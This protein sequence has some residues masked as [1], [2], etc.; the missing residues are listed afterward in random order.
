VDLSSLNGF[1]LAAFAIL[2]II[3]LVSCGQEPT[4]SQSLQNQTSTRAQPADPPKGEYLL[5]QPPQGWVQGFVTKTPTLSM[6][7]YVP[8]DPGDSDWVD[9]VSFESFAADELLDPIE[10]VMD[11]ATDQA[12]TCD[13]F[14]H[15]N[16]LSAKENG[17]PTS[18]RFMICPENSLIGMA[19]VTLIK[20]IQGNDRFYVITRAKRVPVAEQGERAKP[21][22]DAEMAIWSTYMRAIGVCDAELGDVHPCP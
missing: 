10:F 18:V 22:S 14:E 6:V 12:A 8:E 20:A 1:T 9:K 5:A 16:I 3:S 11:I 4:A 2:S 17:Y 13:N 15:F 21:I 7:E 19:Q